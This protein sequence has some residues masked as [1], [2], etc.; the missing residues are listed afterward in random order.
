MNKFLQYINQVLE[1]L[2]I[3]TSITSNSNPRKSSPR[4]QSKNNHLEEN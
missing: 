3:H 1:S 4:T 2:D